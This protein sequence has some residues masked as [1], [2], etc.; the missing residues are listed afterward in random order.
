M[1]GTVKAIDCIG[2]YCS[3]LCLILLT[4]CS[5]V[6]EQK[7]PHVNAATVLLLPVTSLHQE[8][9]D[10]QAQIESILTANLKKKGFK[11]V[12]ITAEQ[13]TAVNQQA[14]DDSGSI[15]SPEVGSFTPLNRSS[16]AKSIAAR[17]NSKLT[18]D[19]LLLPEL[20]LRSAAVEGESVT[21]DSVK[22][23]IELQA[24]PGSITRLP[25]QSK[26]LSVSLTAYTQGG[27]RV[28]QVYGGISLPYTISFI[29]DQ[30]NY[31]LKPEFFTDKEAA[32]GV[33]KALSQLYK[34]VNVG[35]K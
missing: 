28:N 8:L 22:R 19:L 3:F 21:W 13:Y 29:K 2:R 27:V 23:K 34:Q 12:T 30:P 10:T 11:V 9:S 33:K 20:T 5:S 26:G 17:L 6:T 15:Y 16:Y 24:A 35:K 14:L 7:Q 18:F 32:E 1:T 25:E 31:V 4:A